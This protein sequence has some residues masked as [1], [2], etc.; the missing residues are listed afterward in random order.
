MYL[1]VGV[2]FGLTLVL[3]IQFFDFMRETLYEHALEHLKAGG[4]EKMG[5]FF[6]LQ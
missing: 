5:R 4:P 2:T 6:F 1:I 3:R